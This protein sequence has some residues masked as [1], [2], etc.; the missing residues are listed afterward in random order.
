MD[1]CVFMSSP[2]LKGNIFELLKPFLEEL[3]NN[4]ADVTYIHLSEK[5]ILPVIVLFW[6][7]MDM[8]QNM[9][10]ALLKQG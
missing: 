3:E 6:L 8:T 1:F 10:Q 7:H 2:R 4:K 9:V 5:I